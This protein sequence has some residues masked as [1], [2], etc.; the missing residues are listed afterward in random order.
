MITF[1]SAFENARLIGA[2]DE[3]LSLRSAK[4]STAVRIRHAPHSKKKA[5]GIISLS[6]FV[7]GNECIFVSLLLVLE[8]IAYFRNLVFIEPFGETL[9][10]FLLDFGIDIRPYFLQDIEQYG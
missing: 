1:A 5:E 2:L 3:W 6:F 9:L 4:P 10:G 7:L 8:K